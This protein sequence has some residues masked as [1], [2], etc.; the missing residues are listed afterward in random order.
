MYSIVFSSK[1]KKELLAFPN[2]VILSLESKIDGLAHNPRPAGC[3]KL[4]GSVNEYR[5]RAGNY[6][7]IYTIADVVRVVT[8]IK[9]ADRKDA[10]R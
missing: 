9:V 8:I 1:A 5:I 7:I 10:Y 4:Q 3:K 2:R 6:R